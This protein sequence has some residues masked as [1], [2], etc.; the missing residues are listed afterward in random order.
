MSRVRGRH[1]KATEETL[2]SLFRQHRIAG[3]RRGSGV[4][5]K[6]DFV[7]P[8]KRLAV[9]ADGCFWHSCPKH[10]SQPANNK[11]FWSAKLARNRARDTL[12]NRTLKK[13]GW[14]ILRVWQHELLRR[15]Q[16]NLIRRVQRALK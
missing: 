9:F 14:K 13:A 10:R 4:F 8:K 1:N 7:F 16:Q 15:N 5:G 2:K 12:V 3:W 6:P 11:A